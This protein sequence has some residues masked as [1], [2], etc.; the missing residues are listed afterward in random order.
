MKTRSKVLFG[1]VLVAPI[2]SLGVVSAH[3][4]GATHPHPGQV[5]QTTPT[6]TSTEGQTELT[7]DQKAA[8]KQRVEQRKAEMKIR[9]ST[10]EKQRLQSRCKNAQQGSISSLRG[11]I[12]GI[13][14]SREQVYDNLVDRLTKLSDKVEGKG[15]DVAELETQI[16]ELKTKIEGFKTDLDAYKLSVS[17][18]AD[19]DCSSSPANAEAFKASLEAARAAREK[20]SQDVVAIK[21]YVNET[22]KP[23]LQELRKELEKSTTGSTGGEEQ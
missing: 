20:V 12:K 1:A 19:M 16:T 3:D 11:R 15:A 23:T 14:T 17:D 22:I 2:L 8:I 9:I 6:T 5:A 7:G 4:T 13:E 18:L 10:A 21:S